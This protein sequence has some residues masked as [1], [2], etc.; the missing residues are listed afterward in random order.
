MQLKKTKKEHGQ[1]E[2]KKQKQKDQKG[3]KNEREKE[4]NKK[5][6]QHTCKKD[7]S[8]LFTF[9]KGHKQ[10]LSFEVHFVVSSSRFLIRIVF[11]W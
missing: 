1:R 10:R 6:R 9:L 5:G 7:Y 2:I 3:K 4:I 8:H 11:F